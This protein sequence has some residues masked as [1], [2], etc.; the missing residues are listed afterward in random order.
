MSSASSIEPETGSDPHDFAGRLRLARQHSL[1]AAL[2]EIDTRTVLA[3]EIFRLTRLEEDKQVLARW[4]STS[5]EYL[6]MV[7]AAG[8]LF[9]GT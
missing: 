4:R 1:E 8:G 6:G 2:E 3:A 9:G 7:S 5:R